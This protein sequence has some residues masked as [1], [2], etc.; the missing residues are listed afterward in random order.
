MHLWEIQGCKN[1]ERA[2]NMQKYTKYRKSIL[3]VIFGSENKFLLKLCLFQLRCKIMKSHRDRH[4]IITISS[5]DLEE[6]K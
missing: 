3:F 2:L 1:A 4:L 5:A 6:K